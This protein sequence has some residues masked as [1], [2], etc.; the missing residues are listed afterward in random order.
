MKKKNKPS[1]GIEPIEFPVTGAILKETE[2][3]WSICG[4]F[5][6]RARNGLHINTYSS[7]NN[8]GYCDSR[9]RQYRCR[10]NRSAALQRILFV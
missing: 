6:A 4:F 3:R 2:L 1:T 9:Q 5:S 10:L 7:V 8:I